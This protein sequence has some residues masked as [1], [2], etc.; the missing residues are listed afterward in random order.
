MTETIVVLIA[1]S[2]L[3][4]GG[5]PTGMWIAIQGNTIDHHKIEGGLDFILNHFQ[6]PLFPRKIMT[7]TLGYQVEIFKDEWR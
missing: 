5:Q 2:E 4:M 1:W 3:E 7:K 6:E